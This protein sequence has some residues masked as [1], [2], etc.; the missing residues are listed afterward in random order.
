MDAADIKT[1]L[2]KSKKPRLIYDGN[3]AFCKYSV[4]YWQKLTKDKVDYQPYQ[5]VMVAYPNISIEDFKSAVQYFDTEGNHYRAAKASFAT[6]SH[7]PGRSFW[8]TL[9]NK[10]PGFAFISEFIYK[11][12]AKNRNAAYWICK[13]LWGKHPEPPQYQIIAWLMTRGIGLVF[14]IAFFSFTTQ[15]LGL[16]GSQGISPL[17]NFKASLSDQ[18]GWSRFWYAPMVFWF[19]SS[20]FFIQLVGCIG[21]LFA[22]M[23]SFNILPRMSLLILYVLYL[24]YIY[25]GQVFMSFQWDLLLVEIAPLAIILLSLPSL[26]IWLMRWLLFRFMFAAG[27]VKIMSGDHSWLDLTALNFH[28]F[29]QP[30]PSPLAWYADQLQDS[31]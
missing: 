31:F 3:C 5:K 25:A 4:D 1:K 8:M 26:G 14:L 17:I 30:L 22:V 10:I 11:L 2:K 18:L 28:F 6:L 7:A 27:L 15:A 12:I 13:L 16:I 29:T 19:N 20:D 9:Y 24:S 21:M 23:L